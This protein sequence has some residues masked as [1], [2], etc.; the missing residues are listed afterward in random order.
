MKNAP[1]PKSFYKKNWSGVN[2]AF[3]REQATRELWLVGQ[4]WYAGRELGITVEYALYVIRNIL[5]NHKLVG[6][7]HLGVL[8]R[9]LREDIIFHQM[10]LDDD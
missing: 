8:A 9:Q 5:S 4:Q 1:M 7:G 2:T 6:R 3:T 10:P